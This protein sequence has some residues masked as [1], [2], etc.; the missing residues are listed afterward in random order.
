[1]NSR[2]ATTMLMGLMAAGGSNYPPRAI[3]EPKPKK[4]KRNR[5]RDRMAKRSR[6]KN[7]G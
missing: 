6:R 5:N 2:L 3:E 4:S 1:M 7:R